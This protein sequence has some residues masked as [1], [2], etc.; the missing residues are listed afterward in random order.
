[1]VTRTAT[2]STLAVWDT[3]T[4]A[5]LRALQ[6]SDPDNDDCSAFLTYQRLSDGRPRIA[7]GSDET[8]LT[9]WD[10]DDFQILHWIKAVTSPIDE[11]GDSGM[12]LAVYD[13]PTSRGT[14]L[15]TG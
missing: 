6:G 11:D 5:F 4:G 13:D 15:V 3:A 14:R 2:G 12:C 8:H 7:A 10:G 9:I 1:L